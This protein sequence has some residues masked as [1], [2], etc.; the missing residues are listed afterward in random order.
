MG[1]RFS[2]EQWR[3]VA[4]K[5]ELPDTSRIPIEDRLDRFFG[6][7]ELLAVPRQ[8]KDR[9]HQTVRT[10]EKLEALLD[11]SQ[12]DKHF[13]AKRYLKGEAADYSP[14]LLQESHQLLAKLKAHFASALDRLNQNNWSRPETSAERIETPLCSLMYDL[15][16]HRSYILKRLPPVNSAQTASTGKFRDFLKSCVESV[17]RESFNKADFDDAIRNATEELFHLRGGDDDDF[18]ALLFEE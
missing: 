10:I 13:T 15:L 2:D 6:E 16:L 14:E 5:G 18:R 17:L 12:K 1:F 7:H 4:S 9:V 3:D 8:T 11:E